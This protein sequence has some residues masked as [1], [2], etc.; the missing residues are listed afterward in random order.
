MS[1][2]KAV[3][4]IWIL[5]LSMTS[6]AGKLTTKDVALFLKTSPEINAWFDANKQTL[7][8]DRVLKDGGDLQNVATKAVAHIKSKG[9][10]DELSAKVKRAGYTSVEQWASKSTDVTM[11]YAALQ[12]KSSKGMDEKQMNAQLKQMESM[13]ASSNMPKEQKEQMM[14]QMKAAM[15]SALSLMKVVKKV[16]Q[17]NIDA[18]KPFKAQIEALERN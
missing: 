15:K 1:F 13:S 11:A 10:Y 7:D 4:G 18:I 8:M 17:A 6:V 5:T 9:M 3:L 12:M 2:I 16:P 14:A